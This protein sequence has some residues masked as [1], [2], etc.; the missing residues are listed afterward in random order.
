MI[1][2]G[3]HKKAVLTEAD[4]EDYPGM[5]LKVNDKN[6]HSFIGVYAPYPLAEEQGGYHMI[7]TM[8]SKRADYIAKVNGNESFPW[9]VIIISDQDTSLLNNDMVQKLASPSTHCRSF[10][11][12][13]RQGCM[14][15]VERL[16]H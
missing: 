15:L 1:D 12:K 4:L 5:F 6:D 7:N 13:T 9:R 10:M 8:V 3:D 14:G 2:L 16:E 11:D